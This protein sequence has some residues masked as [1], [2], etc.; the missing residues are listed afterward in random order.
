MINYKVSTPVSTKLFPMFIVVLAGEAIFM[1]PFLVPRLYRSL[2][3]EVW[4]VDN[5]EIGMAFS[6]YG[7]TAMLS[8]IFGGPFADKYEPRGLII[9][10]LMVTVV[11]SGILLFSPSAATLIVAYGFFGIST[12]FLMWSAMIKVTHQIGGENDRSSAMGIL[13]GGRGFVAAVM[14]TFLVFLVGTQSD[15]DGGIVNQVYTLNSIYLSI[16]IFMIVVSVVVW[17][18]LN[19][20]KTQGDKFHDWSLGKAKSL[21]KNINL[22]LLALIVLSAYCGYKNVGNYPI[23]MK[24]VKGMSILESSKLTSYI[25][26][27]RPLMA[28]IA[29]IFADKLTLKIK[30]GRFVTLII[31]F[32]FGAIS[33]ILLACGILPSFNLVLSTILLSSCFAFA[34]RSIYFSVF[35]DFKIQ[36]GVLGTAIG[37]VSLVGFL[38][39]FFFGIVTGYFIDEYP[40]QSGFTLVFWFNGIILLMGLIASYACFKR[41]EKMLAST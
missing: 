41:T 34:L 5:M 6:A 10:S 35:G 21:T 33:Q 23:Y 27:A 18:G 38:P 29:G 36:D 24:E 26:W 1:H 16:S 25:F 31:C 17:F 30:G 15:V 37:I 11:G 2:M 8:Y 14:S 20:A 39:D 7:I 12:I 4:N 9:I 28:L 32:G 22:W 40:G 3:M 13:E 19:N